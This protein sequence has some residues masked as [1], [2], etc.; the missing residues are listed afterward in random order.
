[1]KTNFFIKT[2]KYSQYK[3][4]R[5]SFHFKFISPLSMENIKGRKLSRW[6]K[7]IVS[8]SNTGKEKCFDLN[9]NERLINKIRSE[10]RKL[11][12]Q[13]KKYMK[14]KITKKLLQKHQKLETILNVFDGFPISFCEINDELKLVEFN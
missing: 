13:P 4:K 7:I 10:R 8:D 9:E 1:M 14:I 5:I 11:G 12:N 3:R 2:E 6:K